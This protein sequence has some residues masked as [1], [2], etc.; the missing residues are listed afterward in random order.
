MLLFNSVLRIIVRIVSYKRN[1]VVRENENQHGDFS[2]YTDD[3]RY[4][5]RNDNQL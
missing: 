2:L 3:N 4:K 5:A 1:I